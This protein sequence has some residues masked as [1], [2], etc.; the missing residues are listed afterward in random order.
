MKGRFAGI[1]LTLG[2]IMIAAGVFPTWVTVGASS[3]SPIG[4][5]SV[6]TGYNG[7]STAA[8]NVD[9]IVSL[10]IAGVLVF[11]A[12]TLALWA[13]LINRV[14]AFLMGIVAILWAGVLALV[15]SS[16]GRDAI[17][18]LAPT[19]TRGVA[20]LPT[21]FGLGFYLTAGGGVLALLGGFV[22]MF[23][24]RRRAV[25]TKPEPAEATAIGRPGPMTP[26]PA[27]TD[28]TPSRPAPAPSRTPTPT[29]ASSS[30]SSSPP[31]PQAGSR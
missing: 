25:V 14:L 24:R 21:T 18:T 28:G 27:S 23:I 3:Q 31:P 9:A 7:F 16:W 11:L 5:V 15:L 4:T 22:A 1:L 19:V 29:S 10:A 30:S 26:Q 12:F 17:T 2:A 13:A 6:T 8:S 20:T